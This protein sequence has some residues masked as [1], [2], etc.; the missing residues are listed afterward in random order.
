M[1]GPDMAPYT[2]PTLGARSTLRASL[3][4]GPAPAKAWRSPLAPRQ[5]SGSSRSKTLNG[6]RRAASSAFLICGSPRPAPCRS[7][8]SKNPT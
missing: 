3:A 5:L 6:D 2:L 1:G 7:S 4:L 8:V